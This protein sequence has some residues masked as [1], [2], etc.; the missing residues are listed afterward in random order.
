MSEQ[1]NTEAVDLTRLEALLEDLSKSLV[2]KQETPEADDTAEII[3]KSADAIVMQNE[4]MIE[5]VCKGLND[6]LDRLE[7]LE[8]KLQT[9]PALQ[10]QVAKGLSDIANA[11]LP[12]KAVTAEAEESPAE[13]KTAAPQVT[14]G[15]VLSKALEQLQGAEGDRK[16]QLLRAVARLDSNF[17][18]ASVAADFNL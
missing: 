8:S 9:L 13:V 3:A 17:N 2:Q 4:K 11:P 14:K 7:D 12:A 18:P 6:I 5:T 10:E 1:H 16:T 15:E